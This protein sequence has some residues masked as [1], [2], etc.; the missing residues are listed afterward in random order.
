MTW[1]EVEE[2]EKQISNVEDALDQ[3]TMSNTDMRITQSEL[4]NLHNKISRI[5]RKYGHD[6]H[7]IEAL[8]DRLLHCCDCLRERL[9]KTDQRNRQA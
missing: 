4:S 3:W 2:I 7:D 1:Y 5:R 8:S 6:Q 9:I